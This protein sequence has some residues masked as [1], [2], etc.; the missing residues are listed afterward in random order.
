[1]SEGPE[2]YAAGTTTAP[3]GW[4]DAPL[5]KRGGYRGMLPSTWLSRNV[6]VAYAGVDGKGVETSGTLLDWCG[7]GPVFDLAGG[8]VLIAW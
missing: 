7:T 6:R 3:Q 5:P 1:M 4:G 2:T 8:K